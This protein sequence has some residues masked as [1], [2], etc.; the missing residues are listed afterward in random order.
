MLVVTSAGFLSLANRRVGEFCCPYGALKDQPSG[1]PY[2]DMFYRTRVVTN[3]CVVASARN[4][5]TS[6]FGR[7]GDR[8]FGPGVR[9]I[10]HYRL[11]AVVPLD[12]QTCNIIF[13]PFYPFFFF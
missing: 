5:A 10:D 12:S 7:R 8:S 4:R 6:F 1:L 3:C 2:S 13:Y 11:E 9:H